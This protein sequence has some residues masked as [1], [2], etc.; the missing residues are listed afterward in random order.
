MKH[1]TR[2]LSACV[3][4]L[5]L[6][7][8]STN[9]LALQPEEASEILQMIENAIALDDYEQ[10][11]EFLKRASVVASRSR[12]ASIQVE[13]RETRKRLNSLEKA[14]AKTRKARETLEESPAHRE[15]N[16]VVGSY[17]CFEKNEWDR[18]L[19]LL[20][21]AEGALG[22]AAALDLSR[23]A[24]IADQYRL[25]R[26]WL[27]AAEDTRDGGDRR[28]MHLRA[29]EWLLDALEQAGDDDQR[30]PVLQQLDRVELYPSY[31][32]L[33]NTHN[34]RHND[35]GT[36]RCSLVLLQG[37]KRVHQQQLRLKWT[38]EHSAANRV[39]IPRARFDQIQI[40]V[41]EWHG[42]GGGLAEVEVYYET[43]NLALNTL[44]EGDSSP[45]LDYLPQGL[46]D[47]DRGDRLNQLGSWLLLN[48]T[49]GTVTIHLNRR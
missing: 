17:Y 10:A 2:L 3:C 1:Q 43:S 46:T 32:V 29:R 48:G 33:W 25:G 35:R 41:L 27:A 9:T 49:K 28:R 6:C 22:E 5:L 18:G 37:D 14:Y 20:R 40:T 21:A 13:I 36:H 45:N 19:P 12:D 44:A 16:T 34:G 23:P 8:L 15:A 38:P 42:L 31:I 4:G 26:L 39:Q 30:K 24:R 11:Q 7:F 47:G